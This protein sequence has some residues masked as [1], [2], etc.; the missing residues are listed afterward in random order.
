MPGLNGRDL[1]ARITS[2]RPGL[3]VL[4]ISGYSEEILEGARVSGGGTAYLQKPF[5]LGALAAAVRDA[6]A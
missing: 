3:R 4:Y 5:C 1:A 6:M 2:L